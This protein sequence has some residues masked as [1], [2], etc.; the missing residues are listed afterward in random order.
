MS[1]IFRP[2]FD[3][4]K[5]DRFVTDSNTTFSKQVLDEWSGTPAI[6]EIK[7]I[8]QSDGVANDFG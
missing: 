3:T 6:T 5:P 2:E 7:S 1:G 4:P 8:I